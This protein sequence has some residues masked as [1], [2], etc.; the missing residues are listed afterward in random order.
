KKLEMICKFGV[1]Q[2]I[3]E[4]RVLF[5]FLLR[6]VQ[7]YSLAANEEGHL[8]TNAYIS[9]TVEGLFDQLLVVETNRKH[10]C[11]CVLLIFEVDVVCCSEKAVVVGIWKERD[12][13]NHVKANPRE[14]DSVQKSRDMLNHLQLAEKIDC[15]CLSIVI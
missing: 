13:A 6:Q 9:G 12:H 4:F 8:P 5:S 2:A 14:C 15:I 3:G 11:L 7:T 1:V 10:N